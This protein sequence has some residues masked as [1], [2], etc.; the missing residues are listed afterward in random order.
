QHDRAGTI[1]NC[2]A[3]LE[4]LLYRIAQLFLSRCLECIHVALCYVT[5]CAD[6]IAAFCRRIISDLTAQ[7]FGHRTSGNVERVAVAGGLDRERMAF[8]VYALNAV[9]ILTE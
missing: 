3:I 8:A 1:T 5:D 6:D 4:V 7:C 9:R 2:E